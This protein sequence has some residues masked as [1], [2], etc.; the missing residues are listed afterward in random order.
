[1]DVEKKAT[2]KISCIALAGGESARLGRNKLTEYVGGKTLLERVLGTLSSFVSDII[3]VTSTQSKLPTLDN[4]SKIKIVR[5]MFPG[6][7][8]L[9]AIYSGL[10]TSATHYNI[11]VA[12][13]MP[14]LNREL[15]GYMVQ[16]S[17]GFDLVAYNKEDR[18]EPLHAI[19]SRNCLKPIRSLIAKNQLRIIGILPF[20]KTRY[21]QPE[22]I[23]R[24]DP[25]FLSF[26]NIN[27]ESDLRTA[28]KFAT[29]Y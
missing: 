8:T 24:F 3:V 13:D 9:G 23:E 20:I 28:N 2:L 27:T 1:L 17:K 21:L 19:Y 12:C 18:P 6:T 22:E 7:G 26:F 15:L 25:R 11:V 29:M 14:F 5:D 16:I 4:Y 10:K